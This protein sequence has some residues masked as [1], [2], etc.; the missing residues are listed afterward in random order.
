MEINSIIM[1]TLSRLPD[2]LQN[3]VTGDILPEMNIQE[4][5]R[6]I[7]HRYP[8]LLLDRVTEHIRGKMIKGYKNITMNEPFFQGHFP[9]RPIMPGVLQLEAMAQLGG[10]LISHMPDGHGKLAVFAGIDNVR[11]RR[12]VVPGD[13]LDLS[14]ELIRFRLPIGKAKCSASVGGEVACEAELM[15]SLLNN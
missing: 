1:E 4:I 6:F 9:D 10:V 14:C 7:P 11:F 8:F 12:M 5:M 3:A 2:D 13:R 15:F